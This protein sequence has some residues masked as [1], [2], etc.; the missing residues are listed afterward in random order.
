MKKVFKIIGLTILGLLGLIILICLGININGSCFQTFDNDGKDYSNWMANI[1]DETLVNEIVM[2]GSH[3]AGSYGMVW[4]GETQQ[5][6]IDEQ[7]QMGLR[8]FLN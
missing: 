8:Y 3:D 2:P 7:L 5:F 6:N 4:L 1:K